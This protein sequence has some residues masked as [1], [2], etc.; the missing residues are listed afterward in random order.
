MTGA[1]RLSRWTETYLDGE[2]TPEH[3]LD[4]EEHLSGC[5]CCQSKLKFEQA[6]RFSMQRAVRVACHPTV[7]FEARLRERM[8]QERA[9][10]ERM[11]P[12]RVAFDRKIPV[13]AREQ[14]HPRPLTWRSITPLSAAAAAAL[15]FA[16]LRNEPAEPTTLGYSP[17]SAGGDRAPARDTMQTVRDFLDQLAAD[18]EHQA[19]LQQASVNQLGQ[20]QLGQDQLG[21]NS[22]IA[23]MG[24]HAPPT[25]NVGRGR[26]WALPKLEELGGIWEGLHYRNVARAGR[27]PSVHY[28][29]GSH[30]VLL[31]AYDSERVPLRVLLEPNVARNHP[32]FVGTHHGL[33]VAAVERAG[34]GFVATTDLS[35]SEAAELIVSATTH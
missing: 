15:V 21:P 28:R 5:S 14:M 10:Q 35:P 1:C 32:V 4:F 20:D 31:W 33:A 17:A 3:T 18:T 12:Q 27:V 34:Q 29:I 24:S 11:L 7:G 6:L 2:L 26:P 23:L 19:E 25:I 16:A 13:A 8:A 22:G 30:R 9:A